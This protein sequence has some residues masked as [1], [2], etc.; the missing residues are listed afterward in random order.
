MPYALKHKET[1]EL[2]SCT[3][4]N[5]YQFSY[6]GVKLWDDQETAEKE[7][8]AFVAS[9]GVDEPWIWE[10]TELDENQ[11]KLGNVKL[12]NNPNKRVFLSEDGTIKA[13]MAE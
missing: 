5:I 6:Y 3:L 4:V 12:N 7:F 9:Q 2:F 8:A 10:V 13:R 1:S 11:A